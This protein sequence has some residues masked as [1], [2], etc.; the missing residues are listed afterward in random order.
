MFYISVMCDKCGDGIGEFGA[1][2]A[3]GKREPEGVWGANFKTV[4][5]CFRF[6]GSCACWSCSACTK[7]SFSVFLDLY[8]LTSKTTNINFNP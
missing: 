8:F 6:L 5:K 4:K 2:L 1:R 7:L 3:K